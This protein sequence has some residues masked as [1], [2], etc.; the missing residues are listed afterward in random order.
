MF[1]LNIY[2]W[3]GISLLCGELYTILINKEAKGRKGS[4]KGTDVKIVSDVLL[5]L[6]SKRHF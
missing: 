2:D 5:K 1:L 3:N 6:S 4:I